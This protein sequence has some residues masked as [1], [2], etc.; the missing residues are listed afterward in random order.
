MTAGRQRAE[1]R[2]SKSDSS[3]LV[4]EQWRGL[5]RLL[6]DGNSVLLYHLEN[7]YCLVSAARSWH[8][9]AGM[10][11]STL[12]T[13]VTSNC[14]WPCARDCCLEGFVRRYMNQCQNFQDERPITE[15]HVELH[16]Q[17]IPSARLSFM[18]IPSC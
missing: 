1:C 12:V 10:L 16:K 4:Q 8:M 18:F 17:K 6:Q 3:E 15:A 13:Q 2:V 11:S 5:L 7:H 9:D 14:A